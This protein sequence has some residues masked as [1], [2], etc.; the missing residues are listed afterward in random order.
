M[1]HT[2]AQNIKRAFEDW[3]KSNATE[4]WHVYDRFSYAKE[5][6]MD[7][8]KTLVAKFNGYGLKIIGS[9][10]MKF[11]VG[12]IGEIDGKQAFFYITKSYDRF[13]YLDEMAV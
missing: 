5:N 11:S 2:K 6:A 12:F 10:C 3:K 1:T 4:L 13:I 7:Y 9:N 8:C